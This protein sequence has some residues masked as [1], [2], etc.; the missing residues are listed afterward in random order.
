MRHLQHEARQNGQ[1][2]AGTEE[3]TLNRDRYSITR[4][5]PSSPEILGSRERMMMSAMSPG[6]K[7][8][9]RVIARFG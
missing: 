8:S 5:W 9:M 3:F 7:G 4:L 1:E 6:G 2:S